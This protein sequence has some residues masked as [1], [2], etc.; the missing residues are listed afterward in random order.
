M[1]RGAWWGTIHRVTRVRHNLATKPSLPPMH[2]CVHTHTHTHTHIQNGSLH[3]TSLG[4]HLSLM[5]LSTQIL[6][7]YCCSSGESW[8]VKESKSVSHSIMSN[9]CDPHPARLLCPWNSPDKNTGVGWL[10]QQIPHLQQERRKLTSNTSMYIW[11]QS[12]V[13]P[14]SRAPGVSRTMGVFLEIM[15]TQCKEPVSGSVRHI[16]KPWNLCADGKCLLQW[17]ASP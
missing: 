14:L 7:L 11:V 13:R 15:S 9:S 17:A 4:A 16:V 8:K 3:T 6:Y 10:F 12:P 1:N 5:W 2:A